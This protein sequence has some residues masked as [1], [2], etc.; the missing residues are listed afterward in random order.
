MWDEQHY[1]QFFQRLT[2]KETYDYQVELA[3]ALLGGASVILRAPTGSGKTW[4]V[5]A[6]FLYGRITK[7][8][9]VS[10]DRL[11]YALPLRS[12]ASNLY[13][14]VVKVGILGQH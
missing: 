13:Q 10:A 5:I 6:P 11:I 4:A 1:R 2:G 8:V 14:P 7:Q 12:L 9:A 3:Q